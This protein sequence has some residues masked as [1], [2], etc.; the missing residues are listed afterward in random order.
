MIRQ[1]H[2]RSLW[3]LFL[4]SLRGTLGKVWVKYHYT[5]EPRLLELG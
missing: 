1:N 4:L 2:P 3:V 5:V